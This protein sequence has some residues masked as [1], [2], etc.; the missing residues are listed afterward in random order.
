MNIPS[1]VPETLRKRATVLPSLAA[2]APFALI[3]LYVAVDVLNHGSIPAIL[4]RRAF[5]AWKADQ[6]LATARSFVA[7]GGIALSLVCLL[8]WWFPKLLKPHWAFLLCAGLLAPV[9]MFLFTPYSVPDEMFHYG[10]TLRQAASLVNTTRLDESFLFKNFQRHRNATDGYLLARNLFEDNPV[11]GKSFDFSEYPQND[12]VE[13]A[14]S[15]DVAYLTPTGNMAHHISQTAGLALGLKA[16]L[17]PFACFYLGRF[18]A[19]LFYVLTITLA[20]RLTPFLKRGMAVIAL[21]P[22]ALQ[23]ACSYSY[24]N[25]TLACSFLCFGLFAKVADESDKPISAAEVLAVYAMTLFGLAVKVAA[26]PFLPLL[27]AVPA[28]RFRKGL[29]GKLLFLVGVALL[30]LAAIAASLVALPIGMAPGGETAWTFSGLLSHPLRV[31]HVLC[32]T[33]DHQHGLLLALCAFGFGMSGFSLWL[34]DLHPLLFIALLCVAVWMEKPAAPLRLRWAAAVGFLF[35]SA[36]FIAAMM[37]TW[38]PAHSTTVIGLQGRYWTP[39]LPLL[40]CALS[41]GRSRNRGDTPP[42]PGSTG[43][44]RFLFPAIVALH[45]AVIAFVLK[46]SILRGA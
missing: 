28:A 30:S 31:A 40:L 17:Q 20:I 21:T 27:L 43:K 46:H 16:G 8:P 39:V 9:Y 2:L 11:V 44:G 34:P 3:L 10:Q 4:A 41:A 26:L 14:D 25:E 24:D 6:L 22:I 1:F 7:A 15:F 42:G 35:A 12:R 36:Y 13:P 29:G 23:Q 32:N 37:T 45:L 5:P 18:S 38:T 19:M 33:M